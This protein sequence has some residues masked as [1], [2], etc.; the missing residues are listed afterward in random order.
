MLD[1]VYLCERC[2]VASEE[3]AVA[4]V[5]ERLDSNGSI[6]YLDTTLSVSGLIEFEFDAGYDQKLLG[7]YPAPPGG[8]D[9]S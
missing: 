6:G 5:D 3:A 9:G 4:W 2:F 8:S 7:P 1:R